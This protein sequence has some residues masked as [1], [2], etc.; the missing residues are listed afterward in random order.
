MVRWKDKGDKMKE[1]ERDRLTEM[2]F[3]DGYTCCNCGLSIVRWLTSQRAHRI[4][5]TKVNR[6]KYGKH[7]I[8]H[9]DNWAAVC[10]LR[11]NDAMNIGNN[12]VECD[13][14]VLKICSK[15]KAKQ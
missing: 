6:K 14:L 11:C 1:W 12:P 4:A 2:N 10:S 15:L 8:D 5:N 13:K 3:R 9:I 7:I